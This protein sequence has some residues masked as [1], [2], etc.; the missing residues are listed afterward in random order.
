MED[1]TVID[2]AELDIA[3]VDSD[4]PVPLYHQIENDLRRLIGCGQLPPHTILPPE[5]D[6][7]RAY[8]V[9]RHTMR[10]ALS[11]LVADDLISR[12]AGRGTLV[13]AQADRMEFYLDR[14][15]TRQMADMGR[16]AHSKVLKL[17]TDTI[18]Q[19]CPEVFRDKADSS[20]LRLVRLRFGDQEPIALQSSVILTDRCP[21]LGQHDFEHES[22]YDVLARKYQLVITEI[23]HTISA[24]V[25]DQFQAELLQV[26]QDA[27]LLVVKTM[28]SLEDEQVIESTIT[29][30]RADRYEYR[31][32]AT[33]SSC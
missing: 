24:A 28:A 29:Y 4:S 1:R 22:L 17:T 14:S 20:C 32:T 27:P 10:K 18:N 21:D 13:K 33:Y 2:I 19:T 5:K 9:S 11:R 6:L 8:G 3:P 7:C 31:T 15:F 23:Q 25:A 12:R 16:E 30:Y 26:E